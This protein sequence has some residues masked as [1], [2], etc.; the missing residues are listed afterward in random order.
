MLLGSLGF[1]A[2]VPAEVQECGVEAC[3]RALQS[4]AEAR[5][6]DEAS[7]RRALSV[8]HAALAACAAGL[9]SELG[10]AASSSAVEAAARERSAFMW[11]WE[12]EP[13]SLAHGILD[14][15]TYDWRAVVAGMLE[16]GGWPVVVTEA[17]VAA[18]N[19]LARAHTGIDVDH[20]G[21]AGLAGLVALRAA[22]TPLVMPTERVAVVFS[23]RR[24]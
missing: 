17:Q 13:M 6:D 16:S 3:Y 11:A 8:D 2:V 19:D 22:G 18:A 24:R 15:E 7:I 5:G 14:D 4:L 23:G 20:T 21:S 9:H 12:R 10:A 1:D